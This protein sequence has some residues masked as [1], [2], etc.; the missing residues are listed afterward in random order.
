MT[1]YV[2][3]FRE[4]GTDRPAGGSW[5]P[6]PFEEAR[7]VLADQLG[8]SIE[9]WS[10]PQDQ[11]WRYQAVLEEI[12]SIGEPHGPGWTWILPR[13]ELSLTRA[14]GDQHVP[15][16]ARPGALTAIYSTEYRS[17]VRMS[18]VLLGDVGPAE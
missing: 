4:I 16:R 12:R 10:R 13:H 8:R 2:A 5:V 6:M 1:E 11:Q 14:R 7:R 9:R 18:A 3:A 17:L 15:G